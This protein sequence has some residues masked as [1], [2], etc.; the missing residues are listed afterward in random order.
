[1][2]VTLTSEQIGAFNWY[3]D[4]FQAADYQAKE[5]IIDGFVYSFKGTL[6]NKEF[7]VL[8]VKMVCASFWT[9]GYSQ[10]FPVYL[11]APLSKN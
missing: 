5:K 10:I 6:S 2:E 9:S 7:N 3:L 4:K 8:A 1:M 11:A